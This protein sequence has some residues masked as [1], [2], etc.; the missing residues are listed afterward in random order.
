MKIKK[1]KNIKKTLKLINYKTPYKILLSAAFLQEI[2]K[3]KHTLGIFNSISFKNPK[4]YITEC[5]FS[6]YKGE[7][8]KINMEKLK[9]MTNQEKKKWKKERFIDDFARHCNIKKCEKK[10]TA[11]ECNERFLNLK[12]NKYF[13]ACSYK[14]KLNVKRPLIFFRGGELCLKAHNTENLDCKI[15]NDIE[16]ENEEEKEKNA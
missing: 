10:Q 5:C 4:L 13:L 12:K 9:K 11:D 3:Q 7:H 1:Q 15:T 16:I 6:Q 2:N 8:K 14:E